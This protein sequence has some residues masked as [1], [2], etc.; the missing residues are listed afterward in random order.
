MSAATFV[1]DPR[2]V[3]LGKSQHEKMTICNLMTRREDFS[4]QNTK[5][6]F[7]YQGEW[8]KNPFTLIKTGDVLSQSMEKA[9]HD[10]KMFV[11]SCPPGP[12]VLLLLVNP[13]DFTEADRHK[14]RSVI[15]LF[16]QNA[17]NY[18]IVITTQNTEENSY[19]VNQLVRECGQRNLRI[20]LDQRNISNN[21]LQNLMAQIENLV[22]GNRGQ[23]LTFAEE[24]DPRD[25]P[26]SIK[27]C[28]NL[29]LCGRHAARKT[30]TVRAI[31]RESLGASGR[32][33]MSK[34]QGEVCGRQV[35][36]LELPP[37][38]RKPKE[39]AKKEAYDRVSLCEPEGV[40]AF[41]FVLPLQGPTE[42]D[43][44]ELETI[45]DIFSSRVNGFT[46]I[47]FTI[48]AKITDAVL[49]FLQANRDI[50][51]L[52]QSCRGHVI[53]NINDPQQVPEVVQSVENMRPVGS[54]GF[55]K[56]MFAKPTVRRRTTFMDPASSTIPFRRISPLD[57]KEQRREPL[58]MVLIG[59][60]G[61]GKSATGNTILGKECF[62]SKVCQQSV[63]RLCQ[64]ETGEI[65]GRPVVVVDTPGLFDTTLSDDKVKE[66]LGKCISLLAPGPHV[67]LLVLQIGR[68]TQEE[69]RTVE[70]IKDFFGK[71]A[72]DFIII[73]FTRGDDLRK[74][75]FES[76]IEDGDDFVRK[77][78][79]ECGQRYQIFNNNDSNRSQVSEL[80]KKA[81]EMI[82]RNGGAHYTS[83]MF[84][85]AEA[86]IQKEI[87]KILKR[88][89][90]EIQ[91][92]KED[93]ETELKEQLQ[94]KRT[95][96]AGQMAE[97]EKLTNLVVQKIREKEEI[98]K[99]EEE[100]MKWERIKREEM[101][102]KMRE[103]EVKRRERDQN[104]KLL[105]TMTLNNGAIANKRIQY[106]DEWKKETEVWE[107]ERKELWEKQSREE[108]MRREEEQRRLEKLRE[109]YE[110]E[111]EIYEIIK[112]E[113]DEIQR[114]Q[115][116]KEWKEAKEN[117]RKQMEEIQ[118][119]NYEEARKQAEEFN[120]F[121]QKYTRSLSVQLEDTKHK[122]QQQNKLLIQHL[123]KNKV[124]RKSFDMLQKKHQEEMKELKSTLCFHSKEDINK[125]INELTI[126]HEGEINEWIQE[127]VKE[128]AA[129]QNC[130]IL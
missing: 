74:Q 5:R 113:D 54:M 50:Q 93:F 71:K 105:Q 21:D 46:M 125:G 117:F 53:F 26:G 91:K 17:F 103:E 32:Y 62:T 66:E 59:K 61:C 129:N 82:K 77:L 101:R 73:I 98:I 72:E 60:T 20:N 99:K 67:F 88:K 107:Q 55:T 115:E 15:S 56:D 36:I 27:P 118:K 10:I 47:L 13:S 123:T 3:V 65:D 127:K 108:E 79:T 64:K 25:A 6:T 70:V 63:T 96:S 122:Q 97:L 1:C 39:A 86:A 83:E 130:N 112:Q 84:E 57:W 12:N 38:Y 92:Q 9:Q 94:G 7:T 42:E 51:D 22:R 111:K 69:R 114:H 45:R 43:K 102:N 68:F 11:A 90:E 80:L 44:K 121:Q 95:K 120:E 29:V 81:E 4:F 85:M 28:L 116:E 18:A 119:K 52:I 41:M 109:E 35:S 124:H 24:T 89:N 78:I 34:N 128:G 100:R 104:D 14:V 8:R 16:G 87:E 110:Q 40:H 106:R 76:Y 2:I 23:H 75:T 30:E 126:I 37:L 49:R 58:R 33:R 19:S 31:L 48:E